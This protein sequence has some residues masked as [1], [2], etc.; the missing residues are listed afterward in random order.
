MK[1]EFRL[2]AKCCAISTSGK[3][4][5]SFEAPSLDWDLALS[6]AGRHRVEGQLAEALLRG[7]IAGI[8]ELPQEVERALRQARQTITL[9]ELRLLSGLQAIKERLDDAQIDFVLLKGLHTTSRAYGKLGIRT[10]HD[11]DLL[12]DE[13][14]V[15]E[16][17]ERLSQMG[18]RKLAN[19]EDATADFS[20][21]TKI[22]QKDLELYSAD[23][24]ITVDLH[25]RLFANPFLL[26]VDRIRKTKVEA[27][28]GGCSVHVLRPEANIVYL[29]VHGAHH[30]W[31][32]LKWLADFHAVVA[33]EAEAVAAAF[34]LAE[35]L[36]VAPA[37]NQ[38]MALRQAVF[39]DSSQ[40]AAPHG[41]RTRMLCRLAL[42][43]MTHFDEREI[44]SVW[45]ATKPK[46]FSHYLLTSKPRY[47]AHEAAADI[48]GRIAGL[49][50]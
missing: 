6:L 4:R 8:P 20:D 16:A 10:N 7:G 25:W 12:V 45:G 11:I 5:G 9:R 35:E 37:L 3:A 31:S 46:N 30:G 39:G 13:K 36:D 1:P 17:A 2:L 19:G 47:L 32:R 14:D 28:F 33:A 27:L 50:S 22:K 42:F 34:A 43:S 44:E 23:L 41:I 38:A 24:D 29:A 26:P 48:R 49:M 21:A 40:S 15:Q 18:F